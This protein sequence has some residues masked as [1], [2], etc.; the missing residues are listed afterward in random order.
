LA[1]FAECGLTGGWDKFTASLIP[2]CLHY[3][4][5]P[6]LVPL[7][8]EKIWLALMPNALFIDLLPYKC[9]RFHFNPLFL[10][11]QSCKQRLAGHSS[12]ER[13]FCGT[14]GAIY[15]AENS[16]GTLHQCKSI[17]FGINFNGWQ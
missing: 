8:I 10:I 4:G 1:L 3:R 5:A 6:G 7:C 13:K 16:A 15:R 9:K 11:E 2:C 14:K 17:E 12:Q